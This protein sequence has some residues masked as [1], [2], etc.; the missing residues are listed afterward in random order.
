MWFTSGHYSVQLFLKCRPEAGALAAVSTPAST[1]NL[2]RKSFLGLAFSLLQNQGR[3]PESN[4]DTHVNLR[5]ISLVAWHL[6]H[7]HKLVL[8]QNYSVMTKV[9]VKK[10]LPSEI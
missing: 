3:V 9:S 1:W 8:K 7:C 6:V 5:T 10:S 4:T 2:V